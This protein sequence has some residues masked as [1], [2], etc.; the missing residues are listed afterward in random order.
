MK[1]LAFALVM[2]VCSITA[3]AQGLKVQITGIEEISHENDKDECSAAPTFPCHARTEYTVTAQNENADFVFSCKTDYLWYFK[4]PKEVSYLPFDQ[5][6][7]VCV[8]L[9]HVADRVSFRDDGGWIL[10]DG[11]RTEVV[12]SQP[13]TIQR[14]KAR[15]TTKP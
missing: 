13:F 9:F 5:P 15:K 10:A 4:S 6:A 14:E 7:K 2:V 1:N 8:V 3:E 11:I 12:H